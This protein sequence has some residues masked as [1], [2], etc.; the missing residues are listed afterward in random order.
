[1]T[2]EEFCEKAKKIG[3]YEV[4][5]AA[6]VEGISN[7]AL[8]FWQDGNIDVDGVCLSSDRTPDQM[9]Q[10]AEALHEV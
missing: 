6:T 9:W 2:W 1:M 10:V 3:Y 4:G 7:D 5:C 8:T